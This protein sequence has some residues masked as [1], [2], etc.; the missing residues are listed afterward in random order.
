MSVALENAR[1]FDQTQR[2]LEE[3]EQRNT[4]LAVI[5]SIQQ[6]M[7]GVARLSRHHRSRRRQAPRSP[8]HQRHGHPLARSQN[9]GRPLP[10]R[11]PARTSHFSGIAYDSR[12]RSG[13]EDEATHQ[14]LVYNTPAEMAADGRPAIEGTDSSLSCVFVPILGGDRMLGG[15]VVENYERENAFSAADVRL[16]STV[17]A[18][19]GVAL[20]NARLF[21]ETQRLL[22]ETE[23]RNAELA[24]INSIQQGM[25]AEL[26]FRAIVDLVGD[27]LREVFETGDM[28]VW[29]Y[30]EKARSHPSSLRLRARH[31]S[32]GQPWPVKPGSAVD[33][34]L[35]RREVLVAGNHAEQDALGFELV[36]GTDRSHSVAGVPIVGGDRVVGGIVLENHEREHAFAEPDVRLLTTV[37]A[38][39][40]VAL[41]NARLFDE[42]QR[43][44][45]AESQRAAELAVINSI[46]QGMAEKLEFQSIIDLVGDKLRA[47]FGTGDIG[48]SWWDEKENVVHY[49]YAFEH[50]VRLDIPP[51]PVRPGGPLERTL[52]NRQMLLANTREEQKAIGLGA[53]AP[54]TD[55]SFAVVRVPIVGSDRVLGTIQLENYE[56]EHAFGDSE[57][58]LLTTVAASMGVALENA[59]LFD[60]TQ[61]LFK[62]SEQR[63]AELAIINS[64]QQGLAA[65]LDFQA[66]IDLVGDK[67]A[68]IFGTQGM[69][70]ALHDP[71]TNLLT[72]P[73]FLELGK[74]FPVEP[75]LLTRG[76]T[77]HVINTRQPLVVNRDFERRGTEMGATMIG[78]PDRP[79]PDGSYLGVPILKGDAAR[80]VIAIY[81]EHT[82]AF[83]DSDVH[84]LTTLSN[85]MSVALENAR[86]F[87]E[88]QRRTRETAALAEVGRDI[89]STLDLEKVMDRIAEHA[90]DLLH[91][92][93]SAI[94][95][96]DSAGDNYR[97]I[98]ALGAVAA[99][100]KATEIT[101]GKGIIGGIL[102]AGRPEYVNDTASDKRGIQIAG[103]DRAGKRA[104]DGRAADG[105]Q[106]GERC[107]GRVAHRWTLVRRR[108]AGIPDR[109]FL[110]S[111][112]GDRKRAI[113]L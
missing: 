74:R 38:S 2:L 44:F 61:R 98:V 24:V 23:Q 81:A 42:T 68:E 45:K 46:Q 59:R 33:R 1:L 99:Q 111:D 79:L 84:L 55:P 51:T 57:I 95:L 30:D 70:I 50:G 13:V 32:S 26:D 40:G 14:P 109:T 7:A 80:G 52:R 96:P 39:M 19:M 71:Q 53:P 78:D 75:V 22:E 10:L 54:G 67:I 62:E 35:N 43:L 90:R 106:R 91:C 29:S 41:E 92:D 87:D 104:A 101:V 64:V 8:S 56:R 12:G 82:D 113:V 102:A 31:P 28:G 100:I 112:G 110:A 60:E 47:V 49:L 16:L 63:A 9:E 65:E 20:E 66:I 4:E 5:N 21:D 18:S 58:R 72:M 83:T 93:N 69:S 25:A 103:T 108:R 17:A 85:T 86:L 36:P 88:T 37:A 73:Y 48:I 105:R 27:K 3:T 11:V 97:A 107:D 15:I 94:F 34:I 77:A 89:S 76:F 6:G